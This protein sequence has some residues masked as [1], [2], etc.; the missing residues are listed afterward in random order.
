M[1]RSNS[2]LVG[3]LYGLNWV[4]VGERERGLA[5]AAAVMAADMEA[6]MSPEVADRILYGIGDF[7]VFVQGLE[8]DFSEFRYDG[9]RFEEVAPGQVLVTGHIRAR[10]RRSN[11]PLT[12]PFGHLWELR[13]RKAVRIEARLLTEPAS[14]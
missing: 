8:E 1:A 13:D 6:R 2:E 5:A 9:E 12:A 4:A 10:G 3:S 11:M 7:A 14:A